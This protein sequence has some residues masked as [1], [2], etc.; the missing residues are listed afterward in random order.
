[1]TDPVA[2]KYAELQARVG[3]HLAAGEAFAA[4]I[5]VSRATSRPS[6]GEVT[7]RELGPGRL[8]ES[9]ATEAVGIDQAATGPDS[10]GDDRHGVLSGRP[11][12]LA[13]Q[14]DAVV[15]AATV[16]RALA[17][18]GD[19]LIAFEKS[20]GRRRS[21]LEKARD[22]ARNRPGAEP[23][24]PLIPRWECPRRALI[25]ASVHGGRIH[26]SFGDGSALPL[27]TPEALAHH[28]AAAV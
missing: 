3:E 20:P 5:W 27:V 15:P 19:R 17:L 4:A 6:A 8:L 25:A 16:A 26:L 7:R 1:V 9:I 18:T 13:A 14:L 12:S 28:F 10:Y 23:L 11:G 21:L 24:P 2:R 22:F